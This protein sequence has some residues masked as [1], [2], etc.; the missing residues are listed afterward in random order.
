MPAWAS[1]LSPEASKGLATNPSSRTG[2][3]P[4]L[5]GRRRHR[6]A[7]EGVAALAAVL[8]VSPEHPGIAGGGRGSLADGAA[9]DARAHARTLLTPAEA[10]RAIQVAL[11]ASASTGRLE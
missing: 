10:R 4:A 6:P 11:R 7:R 1:V 5:H 3:L 9:P 2:A 8:A